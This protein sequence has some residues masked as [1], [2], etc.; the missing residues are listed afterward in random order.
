MHNLIAIK[1][2]V[3]LLMCLLLLLEG[4]SFK[5]L[6]HFYF[7]ISHLYWDNLIASIQATGDRT[8]FLNTC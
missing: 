4:N 5:E 7:G 8:E 6:E 2:V 3:P 1:M